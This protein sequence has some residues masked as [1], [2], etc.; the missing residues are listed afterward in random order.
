[1]IGFFGEKDTAIKVPSVR[2]FQQ[3]MKEVGVPFEMHMYKDQ[4][5]GFFNEAKYHET[6]LEMDAFLT[7]LG[8][9]TPVKSTNYNTYYIDSKSGDDSNSALSPNKAWKSLKKVNKQTFQAGD[10]ILFKSGSRYNGVLEPKGSGLTNHPIVVSSYGVGKKP[11]I[12]GWGQKSHTLLLN[13]VEHWKVSNL[14]ITNKGKKRQGWRTGVKIQAINTGEMHNI[15][16]SNLEIYDVN[17][18]LVKKEGAGAAILVR[19]GGDINPTRFNDLRIFNNHIHHSGRNGISFHGNSQRDKWFP[20]L[21]VHIKG[22]LIEQVPGDGIVVIASDGA[23]VEHNVLRDFPDILPE[24]DAAAGIWPWSA[25]NTLIQFN[26]VSGHKAKWDGQGFD[27]DFNSFGTIIQYNY[28]HDNYGGFVLVCNKGQDLG[29]NHNKG[30][31]DTIIRGNISINDGIRPYPTHAGIFSPTFHITGP[32][33]NPQIYDNIIIVPKKPKGV[34]KTLIDM[35]NWGGPWPINTL[36]ENN[37]FYF[38]DE[39]AIKHKDVKSFVFK[40]NYLSMPINS[41]KNNENNIST[42]HKF[43]LKALKRMALNKLKEYKDNE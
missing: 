1:M 25:D 24:G 37:Q 34:D 13:N 9:I 27:S 29:K 8:F 22:N 41:I 14:A 20:N 36:F 43:D 19:N 10:R 32:V 2:K 12:N 15:E 21:G 23:I 40:N 4:P 28:S 39:I 26:E 38:E 17:G 5:H 42:D 3:R 33:E 11:L 30:T 18:S 35:D 6:V 16:L 31:V 7:K